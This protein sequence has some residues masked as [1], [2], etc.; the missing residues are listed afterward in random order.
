MSRRTRASAAGPLVTFTPGI[1]RRKCC[2]SP[3]PRSSTPTTSLIGASAGTSSMNR[4]VASS[5]RALASSAIESDLMTLQEQARGVYLR[6]HVGELE[7]D[8]LVLGNRLAERLALLGVAQ[9]E[10]ERALG[11]A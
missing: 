7:L 10:L 5:I 9:A 11:D 8:R 3:R 1:S 4:R 6:G 2:T